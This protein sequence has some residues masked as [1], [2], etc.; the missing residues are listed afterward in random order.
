MNEKQFVKRVIVHLNRAGRGNS[1]TH[2]LEAKSLPDIFVKKKLPKSFFEIHFLSSYLHQQ[3]LYLPHPFNV[4]RRSTH[5][6]WCML[7][8]DLIYVV[9]GRSF[10]T[11][12]FLLNVS[13]RVIQC[14]RRGILCVVMVGWW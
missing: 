4:R 9:A 14:L 8:S 2:N 3:T 1:L 7:W 5:K 13:S 6:V 10:E 11:D 12:S